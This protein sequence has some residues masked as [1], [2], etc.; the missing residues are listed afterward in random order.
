MENWLPY[1]VTANDLSA[2]GNTNT[3]SYKSLQGSIC[4][5]ISEFY[6]LVYMFL[7]RSLPGTGSLT[8]TP[9]QTEGTPGTPTDIHPAKCIISNSTW[10]LTVT[11]I[12]YHPDASGNLSIFVNLYSI[13]HCNYKHI[14]SM[15]YALEICLKIASIQWI[16]KMFTFQCAVVQLY[17]VFTPVCSL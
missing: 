1:L 8:R 13:L 15:W 16:F 5:A 3:R 9:W 2:T 11:C 17:K 14:L 7:L 6:L 12:V 4:N 10:S